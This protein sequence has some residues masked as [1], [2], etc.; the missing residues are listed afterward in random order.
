M[1][2]ARKR[3]VVADNDPAWLDLIVL[4]LELE[5][6]EVVAQAYSGA[7]ALAACEAEVPDVLVVDHRM[8]P[9]PHGLEVAQTVRASH[10]GVTVV[11][12]TNYEDPALRRA[13]EACG[14]RFVL[15]TNLRALREMVIAERP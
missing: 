3:I 7:D 13:V 4:D 9:G 8:P 15:K 6:H 11:V 10:P 2:A 1:T 14:A 12:F 5:G